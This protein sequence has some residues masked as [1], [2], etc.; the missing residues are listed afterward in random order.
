MGDKSAK[1]SGMNI[2][3]LASLALFCAGLWLV[4]SGIALHFASHDGAARSSH[5]FMTIH[6]TA[7]FL[8]LIAAVVHVMM[9]WKVLTHYVK[10]KVGEYLRFKRELVIAVLGVS[11]FIM[12]VAF[13]AL[14][15]H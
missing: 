1:L 5:L 9:N 8:F 4:P 13:H 7:S 6:N 2:R 12:L 14:A 10:A 3:A 15:L 11:A